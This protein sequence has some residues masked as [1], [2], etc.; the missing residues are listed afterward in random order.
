VYKIGDYV[1]CGNNGICRIDEV[2]LLEFEGVP[3]DK[4]YYFLSPVNSNSSKVY[5]PVDND[6]TNM[7]P[8]ISKDE[9]YKLI[10]EINI[11]EPIK[12]INEKNREN[13]YKEILKTHDC[14]EMLKIIKTVYSRRKERGEEGKKLVASDE[15]YLKLAKDFL[16]V[17]LAIPLEIKKE[18]VEEIIH[19]MLNK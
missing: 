1:V 19:V 17:E 14:R 3:K 16:I 2:G 9:A 8:I 15:K 18:E 10:K 7:R 4:K 12:V 5:T 13:A 6:K 11:I